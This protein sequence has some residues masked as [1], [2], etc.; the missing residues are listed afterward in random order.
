MFN[1]GEKVKT[2][3]QNKDF[4]TFA[5]IIEMRVVKDKIGYIVQ[6]KNGEVGTYFE[7]ELLKCE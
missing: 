5:T 6:F 3:T 2:N 4:N 7:N 1:L